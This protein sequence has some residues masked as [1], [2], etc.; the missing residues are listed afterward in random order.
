MGP[1]AFMTKSKLFVIT[2]ASGLFIFAANCVHAAIPGPIHLAALLDNN[3]TSVVAVLTLTGSNLDFVIRPPASL[4]ARQVFIVATT[5]D[6]AATT[7]WAM[8]PVSTNSGPHIGPGGSVGPQGPCPPPKE[9]LPEVITNATTLTPN[10]VKAVL[11]GFGST[12]FYSPNTGVTTAYIVVLDS[13]GDG[14]LDSEDLCPDTPGGSL[15]NSDGCSIDQLAPCDGG[16]KNHGE[17]VRHFRTVTAAFE[18]VGLITTK[19]TRELDKACAQAD[20]GK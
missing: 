1:L 11:N 8:P 12:V 14:V 7:I 9:R 15:V 2:C 20:C 10:E 5:N 17:F 6:T 4:C 13:D 19:Q 16:W 18:A 3:P